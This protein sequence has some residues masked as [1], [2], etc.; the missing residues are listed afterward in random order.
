M[1]TQSNTPPKKVS[2]KAAKPTVGRSQK[3]SIFNAPPIRM[4]GF[5]PKITQ[6]ISTTCPGQCQEQ[7]VLAV[8]LTLYRHPEHE[9]NTS[10]YRA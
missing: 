3:I 7:I 6:N 2:I 10:R 5:R 8:A 1:P 9:N 4:A